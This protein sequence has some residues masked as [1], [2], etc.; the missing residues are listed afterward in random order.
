VYQ[1]CARG[2]SSIRLK[3]S[4]EVV[5]DKGA[6]WLCEACCVGGSLHEQCGG[7][8]N[9]VLK[10]YLGGYLRARCVHHQQK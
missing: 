10:P 8:C 9:C 6:K 1:L 7:I 2:T 3:L 4:Y 5:S